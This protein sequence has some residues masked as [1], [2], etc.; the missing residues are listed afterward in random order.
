MKKYTVKELAHLLESYNIGVTFTEDFS[1][2]LSP[3]M[4]DTTQELINKYGERI[5]KWISFE[6]S[7]GEMYQIIELE[8]DR[9]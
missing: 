8:G 2:W 5:I 7:D 1:S 6:S 4:F 3:E 9:G